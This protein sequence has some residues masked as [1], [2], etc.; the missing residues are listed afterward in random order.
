MQIIPHTGLFLKGDR[1]KESKKKGEDRK[2]RQ[3]GQN[4]H[5][6]DNTSSKLFFGIAIPRN[7]AIFIRP[8]VYQ[9]ISPL[10]GQPCYIHL[11]S[12]QAIDTWTEL[13]LNEI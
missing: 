1:K 5:I 9:T 2:R 7:F 11:C 3:L 12:Q 13:V 6:K 10:R 8:Y 4:I